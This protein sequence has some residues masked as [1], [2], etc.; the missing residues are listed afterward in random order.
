MAG[1]GIL[2]H[3]GLIAVCRVAIG[4]IFAFAALAKLGDLQGFAAQVHN[5]R[6]VPV[7]LENLLAMTL[8]WIELVAALAL[9]L[10]IRARPAAA[11]A[12]GLMAVFTVAVALALA[13]GLDIECGC[14]GTADASRVGLSKI[15]QN[16]GMAAIAFLAI[17]RRSPR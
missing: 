4:L 2:G 10:G 14:F 1:W 17:G 7:P 15:A 12:F 5:F 6:L 9:V 13:R 11:L 16:L 3:R 8:P